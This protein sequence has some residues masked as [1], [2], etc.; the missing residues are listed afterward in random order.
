MR[1]MLH[2]KLRATGGNPGQLALATN[3]AA[4]ANGGARKE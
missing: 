3:F 2:R 4:D 1:A